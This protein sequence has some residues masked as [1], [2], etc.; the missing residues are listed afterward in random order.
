ML[1][2]PQTITEPVMMQAAQA[3]G[4]RRFDTEYLSAHPGRLGCHHPGPRPADRRDVRRSARSTW[5]GRTAPAARSRPTWT[6]R[7][8][9]RAAVGG[10]LHIIFEADLSR[11]RRVPAVGSMY[12]MVQPGRG[13]RRRKASAALRMIKP[14]HEWMLMWGYGRWPQARPR[15]TDEFA[16]ELAVQLVGDRED[17]EMKVTFPA[18]VDG[19][20]PLFATTD[21]RGRVFCVGRRRAPPPADQRAR[22]QCL[23]PGLLQP[24]LEAR[25]TSVAGLASPALLDTYKRR[26]GPGRRGR[27]W[28]GPTRASPTPAVSSRPST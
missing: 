22:L 14:W 4:A 18:A 2:A 25:I 28:S 24:G 17:F 1:D 19:E 15:I 8:R 11:F 27:S 5:S 12:W 21:A 26:A 6:C 23:D 13:E 9:G 3:R 10:A 7:S 16:R 20:P